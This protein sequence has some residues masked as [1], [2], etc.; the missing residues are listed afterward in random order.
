MRVAGVRQGDRRANAMT[1]DGLE[2]SADILI[3]ADSIKSVV[4]EVL[5]G[6]KA[7]RCTGCVAWRGLVPAY[8]I[9][10][11][12]IAPIASLWTARAHTSSTTLCAV[13]DK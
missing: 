7:P 10:G 5:F 1:H 9:N 11:P 4:R 6:P 3:G 2:H 13:A 8:T 12:C